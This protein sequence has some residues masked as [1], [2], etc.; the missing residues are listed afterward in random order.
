MKKLFLVYLSLWLLAISCS[1]KESGTSETT[2]SSTGSPTSSAA[3]REV[4]LSTG[5]YMMCSIDS[6][7]HPSCWHP[8]TTDY[9]KKTNAELKGKFLEISGRG[10]NMCAITEEGK[11]FCFTPSEPVAKQPSTLASLGKF[12]KIAAARDY[13]CAISSDKT[14]SCYKPDFST[15]VKQDD[16][17]STEEI[18]QLA[19]G[20]YINGGGLNDFTCMI[21]KSRILACHPFAGNIVAAQPKEKG[22]RIVGQEFNNLILAI[23]SVDKKTVKGFGLN[24][25]I[26]K[27]YS[28]DFTVKYKDMAIFKDVFCGILSSNNEVRCGAVD[29]TRLPKKEFADLRKLSLSNIAV[30]DNYTCGKDADD[31]VTCFVQKDYPTG[32][33]NAIAAH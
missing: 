18:D 13:F 24:R 25:K 27:D 19:V 22:L 33:P 31:I 20:Q 8:D 5:D 29:Q 15:A 16:Y 21:S 14:L 17:V 28:I 26:K 3:I 1:D 10:K 2:G 11:V 32:I 12:I 7:A 9:A 4:Y 6:E 30:G 23:L